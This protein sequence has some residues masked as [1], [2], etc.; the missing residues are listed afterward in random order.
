M[1][2]L[3]QH[4]AQRRVL[5]VWY[6]LRRNRAAANQVC[7]NTEIAAQHLSSCTH[8]AHPKVIN[9]RFNILLT[10][11]FLSDLQPFATKRSRVTGVALT[12]RTAQS[13]CAMR[14]SKF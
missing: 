4:G 1:A 12:S 5:E 9:I 2:R 3:M 10:I 7:S 6:L 8:A 11:N 14:R 13:D